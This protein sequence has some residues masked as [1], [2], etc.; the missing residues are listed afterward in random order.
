MT[1]TAL[2]II[3]F[4]RASLNRPRAERPEFI[5]AECDLLFASFTS[6]ATTVPAPETKDADPNHGV[7][8]LDLEPNLA[9][10]SPANISARRK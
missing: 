4:H 6:A 1:I 9:T 5:S 7:D 3:A 2:R 8:P 10:P